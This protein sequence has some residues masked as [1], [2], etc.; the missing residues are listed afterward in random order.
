MYV[1]KMRRDYC[2]ACRSSY[3]AIVGLLASNNLLAAIVSGLPA[4]IMIGLSASQWAYLTYSLFS[5]A[6]YTI[7]AFVIA[8]WLIAGLCIWRIYPNLLSV[9]I[10]VYHCLAH[11]SL[12]MIIIMLFYGW[13]YV[14]SSILG[15]ALGALF[16]LILSLFFCADL[17]IHVRRRLYGAIAAAT[18]QAR[19]DEITRTISVEVV[20]NPK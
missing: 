7:L 9:P 3:N 13:K 8:S 5:S 14:P 6:S 16:P 1:I 11:W 10:F 2:K 17:L 20:G 18:P 4:Y 15:P 19:A 12:V